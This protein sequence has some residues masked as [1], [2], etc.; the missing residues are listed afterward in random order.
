[1]RV[2]RVA[3][4]M[5]TDRGSAI[6]ELAVALPVLVV[7]LIGT[8][9]FARVFYTGISLTNAARAGAQF[10]ASSIA[11]STN[12]AG[13][14]NAATSAVN[15][16]GVTANATALCQCATDAGVFSPTSPVNSCTAT[17][18]GGHIVNTVTVTTSKTFDLV[19]GGLPGVPNSIPLTRTATMRVPN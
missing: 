13:M 12:F 5:A 3:R 17:C 9:D 15:I 10:G 18:S 8:I 1:M 7:I 4:A 19:I 2:L 6:I 16:T 11:Q 14:R